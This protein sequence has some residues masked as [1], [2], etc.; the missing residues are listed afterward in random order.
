[1][2][3]S[4]HELKQSNNAKSLEFYWIVEE[5]DHKQSTH[6]SPLPLIDVCKV[7]GLSLEGGKNG[8]KFHSLSVVEDNFVKRRCIERSIIHKAT[9]CNS[10]QR[11]PMCQ[12]SLRT[13]KNAHNFI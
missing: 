5:Y 3:S 13:D 7:Y 1:M 8:L 4:R 6:V 9:K 2:F 11:F 12:P 10:R